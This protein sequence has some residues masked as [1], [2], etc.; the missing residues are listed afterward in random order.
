MSRRRISLTSSVPASGG[1]VERSGSPTGSTATTS[2]WCIARSGS[3][4]VSRGWVLGRARSGPNEGSVLHLLGGCA[5]GAQSIGSRN[6]D[7]DR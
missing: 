4:A 1:G 2:S 5:G 3:A 6:P 7:A